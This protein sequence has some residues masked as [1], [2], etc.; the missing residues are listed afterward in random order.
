MATATSYLRYRQWVNC[1]GGGFVEDYNLN[2]TLG[3]TPVASNQKVLNAVKSIYC[4]RAQ[5]LDGNSEVA[6]GE[7]SIETLPGMNPAEGFQIPHSF[8]TTIPP[9]IYYPTLLQDP[10]SGTL[11]T[12][13]NVAADPGTCVAWRL[14][15]QNFVSELRT[16][17]C[18]R[19]TWVQQWGVLYPNLVSAIGNLGVN[20]PVAGNLY[21]SFPTYRSSKTT[22]DGCIAFFMLV[23]LVNTA[24]VQNVTTNTSVTAFNITPYGLP[25]S[26]GSPATVNPI[27]A[28]DLTYRKIGEG[29]PKTR[30]KMQ[31]FGTHG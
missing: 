21:T 29:W 27:V 7:I 1:A 13:I 25:N 17:R 8:P 24:L 6:N 19:S 20:P 5:L 23:V 18:M 31:T 15:T 3:T 9:T 28:R 10:T 11:E 12:T 26:T 30:G 2:P 16:L 4:L 14:D 22:P